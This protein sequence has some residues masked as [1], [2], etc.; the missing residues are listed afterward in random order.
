MEAIGQPTRLNYLF[1]LMD[2]AVA[3]I[4]R[5]GLGVVVD[6]HPSNYVLF[7]VVACLDGGPLFDIYG[8]VLG[9]FAERYASWPQDTLALSLFNEPPDA[10]D[11]AGHWPTMQ[12][13]L[14]RAARSFM[15]HHTLI[16]TA[17][18]YASITKTAQSDPRIFDDNTLWHV[19]PYEPPLFCS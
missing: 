18:S 9:L 1:G 2:E 8:R 7:K 11:F 19:H 16:L 13:A 12:A 5:A 3:L 17:D 6:L 4:L 15:R 14:Y 10:S